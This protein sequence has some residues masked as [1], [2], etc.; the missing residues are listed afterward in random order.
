[1]CGFVDRV[2]QLLQCGDGGTAGKRGGRG[3]AELSWVDIVD[4]C[5]EHRLRSLA[6]QI[7]IVEEVCCLRILCNQMRITPDCICK[8]GTRSYERLAGVHE[9]VVPVIVH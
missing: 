6:E 8:W 7:R 3:E 9:L 1:M 5:I 4:A 2:S